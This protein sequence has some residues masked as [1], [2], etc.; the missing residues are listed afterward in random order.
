MRLKGRRFA[1]PLLPPAHH[2]CYYFHMK[3]IVK[4]VTET[5]LDVAED[6]QRLVQETEEVIENTFAP[7][8]EGLLKRFPTLFILVVTFGVS[9]VVFSVEQLLLR[10]TFFIEH[11]WISL[12][13]GVGILTLTGTLYKKLG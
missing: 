8:R 3:E 9:L 4:G 12:L 2:L 10:S 1:P 13:F 7:V 6:A 5:T 11:P